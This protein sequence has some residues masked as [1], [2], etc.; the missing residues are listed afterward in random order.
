MATIYV[1]SG[2]IEK[3]TSSLKSW[4]YM[5]CFLKP[6]EEILYRKT[7]DGGLG[8]FH[9]LSKVAANLIISFIQT[10]ANLEYARNVYH[11]ALFN[12][13]IKQIGVRSP[14]RPPYFWTNSSQ[15]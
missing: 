11:E 12:Y 15:K 7:A 5:D 6:E 3:M 9:I 8:M 4:M 13:Y 10:A 1:R 14:A 2:D